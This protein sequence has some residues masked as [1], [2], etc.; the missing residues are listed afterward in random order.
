MAEVLDMVLKLDL[1]KY[2][3]Q[4]D[5]IEFHSQKNLSRE[6]RANIKAVIWALLNNTNPPLVSR[7]QFDAAS[8][9]VKC[10]IFNGRKFELELIPQYAVKT[11]RMGLKSA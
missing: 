11:Y 1:L 4:L 2:N 7:S 10:I 9:A 3:E 6:I 5:S 8:R